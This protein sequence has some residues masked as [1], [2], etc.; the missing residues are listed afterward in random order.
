MAFV[1]NKEAYYSQVECAKLLGCSQAT[2]ELNR[3][4]GGG[5]PFSRIG[6]RIYYSGADIAE[7]LERNRR[8]STAETPPSPMTG[9]GR[10]RHQSN[11]AETA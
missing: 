5:I 8:H 4:A 3:S 10:S 1:V 2:L 11:V 9:R 7:Y 6:R